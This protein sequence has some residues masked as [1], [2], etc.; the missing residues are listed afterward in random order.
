MRAPATIGI[1]DDLPS[2]EAGITLWT[3]NDE[4]TRW[5]NLLNISTINLLPGY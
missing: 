1:D 3:T 4:Q 2:C 5:L